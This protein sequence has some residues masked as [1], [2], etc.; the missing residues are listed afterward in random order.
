MERNI[1]SFTIDLSGQLDTMLT[2]LAKEKHTT[3]A[4]IVR[5]AL[6]SYAY[7]NKQAE[8]AG[9]SQPVVSIKT[10]DGQSSTD[11]MLP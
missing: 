1:S 10:P 7:I 6:A 5:R 11:I 2:E 9:Q 3:K 8:N 4:D